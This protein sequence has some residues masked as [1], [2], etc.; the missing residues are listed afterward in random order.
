[1]SV[2]MGQFVAALTLLA[3]GLF[4]A[5]CAG[6]GGGDGSKITVVASDFSFQPREV[7]VQAQQRFTVTLRNKGSVLHDWTVDAIP[8]TAVSGKESPAH[9]MAGMAGMT[10]TAAGEHALHVAAAAGKSSEVTF[11]AAKPGEYTFYC[12]VLGHRQAGMEG[13]I[14]VE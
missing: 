2:R 1:M 10:G 13:K 12:T 8:V 9:D 5:G 11:T 3:V 14:I 4:L 7:R 6:G